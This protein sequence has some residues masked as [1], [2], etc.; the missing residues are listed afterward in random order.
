M[1]LHIYCRKKAFIITIRIDTADWLAR[2]ERAYTLPSQVQRTRLGCKL[3][4][5]AILLDQD[6]C[7]FRPLLEK[8]YAKLH[9]DYASLNGGQSGDAA[10]DLTGY[11][12]E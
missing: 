4:H 10:E 8:A 1:C 2:V 5:S 3:R 11:V 12:I 6:S 9:G 7:C